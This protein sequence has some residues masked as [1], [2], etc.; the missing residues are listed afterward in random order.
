MKSAYSHTDTNRTNYEV[1]QEYEY[2]FPEANL[3]DVVSHPS[4]IDSPDKRRDVV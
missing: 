2:H 1:S 3:K 4:S